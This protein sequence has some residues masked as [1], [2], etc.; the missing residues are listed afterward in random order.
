MPR[1][2]LLSFYL[3]LLLFLTFLVQYILVI[4]FP[5]PYSS[6]FPMSLPTQPNIHSLLKNKNKKTKDKKPNPNRGK[7]K[8][9]Q[10]QGRQIK[11]T[12]KPN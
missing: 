8:P 3:L 9:S 2:Y 1:L 4:L 7:P 11:P 12:H 6:C 5:L 10:T